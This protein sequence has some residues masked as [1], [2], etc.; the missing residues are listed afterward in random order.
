MNDD[1][2]HWKI[3]HVAL[4]YFCQL[5]QRLSTEAFQ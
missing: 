4:P 5:Y 2:P 1:A 3:T